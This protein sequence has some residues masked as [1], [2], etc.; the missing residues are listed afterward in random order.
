MNAVPS[1]QTDGI[2][3]LDVLRILARAREELEDDRRCAGR[4]S[5][6]S[7]FGDLVGS[8]AESSRTVPDDRYVRPMSIQ[9]EAKVDVVASSLVFVSRVH[10]QC[11]RTDDLIPDDGPSRL[12]CFHPSRHLGSH[13]GRIE[14][15]LDQPVS[16]EPAHSHTLEAAE[17]NVRR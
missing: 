2:N 15:P 17:L 7:P 10:S 9:D 6:D 1:R 11:A 12:E 14:I 4:P 5:F 8:R 3:W 16:T 13:E